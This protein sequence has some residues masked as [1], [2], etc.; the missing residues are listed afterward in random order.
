[1]GYKYTK[2]GPDTEEA[3]VYDKAYVKRAEELCQRGAGESDLAA[4]LGVS[5]WAIKLWRTIHEDFAK[6]IKLGHERADDRVT[7]A[8]YERCVG[9]TYDAIKPMV[10]N[11]GGN[12]GSVIEEYHFKEHCPPDTGACRYWLNNRRPDIW[13]ER[14][15]T[16]NINKDDVKQMSDAEL[17]KYIREAREMELG[18]A[19]GAGSAG[20]KK[21]SDR[22]H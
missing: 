5:V 16:T 8:L 4:A 12:Q 7:M 2:I 13:R 18:A 22:V 17:T 19:G 14:V 15:E 11:Q 6:A 20:S 1:M 21:E 10:V 9:Y 3:P